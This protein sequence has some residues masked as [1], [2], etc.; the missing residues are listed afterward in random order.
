MQYTKNKPIFETIR[1]VPVLALLELEEKQLNHLEKEINREVQRA[2][3]ALKWVQGI[4][5]VK[6]SLGGQNPPAFKKVQTSRSDLQALYLLKIRRTISASVGLI[7][8]CLFMS[9]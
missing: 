4:Q 2:K 8:R 6:K 9:I 5:R 7:S 1:R 3:L